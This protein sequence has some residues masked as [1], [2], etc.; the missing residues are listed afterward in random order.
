MLTKP[1]KTPATTANPLPHVGSSTEQLVR[2]LRDA[3]AQLERRNRSK[4]EFLA[5]MSHEL[6]TPLHAIIGFSELLHDEIHAANLDPSQ[7]A[8][9]G[10][11]LESG[12]HLLALINDVLD[13]SRVEAG[14]IDLRREHTSSHDVAL[15]TAEIVRPLAVKQGVTFDVEASHDAPQ[16][17]VDPLRMKQVLYNLLSNAIKFTPKGGRVHLRISSTDDVVTIAVE[18]TGIG[19]RAEDLPRLFREFERLETND[20]HEGTG[21]GLA[22]TKRLV[23]LHGGSIHVESELGAGSTFRVELPVRAD[24]HGTAE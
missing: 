14:R 8:Y 2:D 20:E 21:L 4:S 9:V 1:S 17:Y 23:E 5:N 7:R 11:I 19:M 22:L 13:M 16:I 6:R 12:R 3:N 18:D 24:L 15:R 10:H